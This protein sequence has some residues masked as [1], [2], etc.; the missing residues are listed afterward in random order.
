M[1]IL[2]NIVNLAEVVK[3]T[4]MQRLI[5]TLGNSVGILI[6]YL[7]NG[8]FQRLDNPILHI[9]F[10]IITISLMIMLLFIIIRQFI[11]LTT[12]SLSI[13]KKQD[14]GINTVIV[15][16]SIVVIGLAVYLSLTTF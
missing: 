4:P 15:I 9:L 7:L 10:L 16:L 8:L 12:S 6:Y 13:F 14:I 2:K 5:A 3:Y 1:K 11:I